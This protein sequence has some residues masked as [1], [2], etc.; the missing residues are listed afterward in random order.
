MPRNFD[1]NWKPTSPRTLVNGFAYRLCHNDDFQ[2]LMAEIFNMYDVCNELV[3]EQNVSCS[4][5]DWSIV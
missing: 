5:Q 2:S 1:I 3:L 4:I